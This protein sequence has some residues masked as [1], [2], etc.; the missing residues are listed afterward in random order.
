MAEPIKLFETFPIKWKKYIAEICELNENFLSRMKIL[1]DFILSEYNEQIIFPPKS[2]LFS[3]FEN[4]EPENVKCVI[5]GQDP[6]HGPGQAHGLAFSVKTGPV[7]PSLRNI[8]K[9]YESDLKKDVVNINK[10]KNLTRWKTEGVLLLN[11][12]LTV[13]KDC[14]KSHAH[15]GWEVF[16]DLIIKTISHKNNKVAFVLWGEDAQNKESII[17]EDKHLI[18]K[19]SHPSPYSANRSFFGSKPFSKVNEFLIKNSL[20]AIDW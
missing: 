12:V 5:L 7:P 19:S 6:Y 8:I 18:I 17:E 11:T 15:K 3:A 10:F 2:E 4:L 20:T 14:A 1:S 9:E 16:T 13:R